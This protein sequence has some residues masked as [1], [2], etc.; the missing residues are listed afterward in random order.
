MPTNRRL[1][2]TPA[3]AGTAEARR[4]IP[5]RRRASVNFCFWDYLNG[6]LMAR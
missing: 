2:N 3:E 1:M 5:R 4:M 6:L